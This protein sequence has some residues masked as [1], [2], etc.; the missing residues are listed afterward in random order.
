MEEVMEFVFT[1]VAVV[2]GLTFS[3]AVAIA[4][5]ELIFGKV[6][7]VM[8]AERTLSRRPP[9]SGEVWNLCSPAEVK[10]LRVIRLRDRTMP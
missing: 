9:S 1:T 7:C 3:L 4:V 5:E 8:F 6:L 10:L 2:G